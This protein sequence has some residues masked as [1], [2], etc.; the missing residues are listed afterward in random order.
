[1]Q[2]LELDPGWTAGG[3]GVVRD[4]VAAPDFQRV[5][6]NLGGGQFDEPLG[7]RGRDRMTDGAILAH[8]VL[9]LEHDARAGT[10]VRADVRPAGEVDDLVGLDAG[11]ARIDRVRA[12]AG[13]VVDLPAGDGAVAL[14]PDLRLYAMVA[15]VDVGDE[16]LDAVG[17]ELD[18]TL[19]Q[20]GE[21][22]RRHL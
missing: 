19:E 15:G 10:V 4:E 13:E 7:H 2:R 5:H 22:D 12:D 20:F 3:M 14:D 9:V 11:C 8:D 21:R 18:R 16:A 17:D 1:R 6:A